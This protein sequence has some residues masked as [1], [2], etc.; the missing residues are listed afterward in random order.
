MLE[1]KRLSGKK[2]H[3]WQRYSAYYLLIFFP[4]LGWQTL[5]FP[6]YADIQTLLQN[7]FHGFFAVSSLIA[8]A[9]LLIHLWVGGRDILIDYSLRSKTVTWLNLYQIILFLI[10]FDLCW[11]LYASLS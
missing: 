2:A 4:Y 7:Q 6:R 1:M 9:L 3:L 5:N 11:V 8:A 10:T